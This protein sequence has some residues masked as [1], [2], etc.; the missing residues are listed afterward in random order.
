MGNFLVKVI[1]SLEAFMVFLSSHPLL[2]VFWCI[3][4][5]FAIWKMSILYQLSFAFFFGVVEDQMLS[6]H[7]LLMLLFI[8][9][10]VVSSLRFSFSFGLFTLY[11]IDNI[12]DCK[13]TWLYF[14][15]FISYWNISHSYLIRTNS[16]V[17]IVLRKAI[18]SFVLTWLIK[19]GCSSPGPHK[20]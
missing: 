7:T 11:I 15:S 3:L 6:S 13:F 9:F 5:L 19:F 17:L 16:Q 8:G 14:P 12:W 4:R 18:A 10:L 1:T 20:S 2:R